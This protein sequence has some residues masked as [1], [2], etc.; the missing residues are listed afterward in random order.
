MVA[1]AAG[2]DAHGDIRRLAIDGVEN[3]AGLVVVAEGGVGIAG[4]LDGFASDVDEVERLIG[5]DLAGD[6]A[7]A[8]G[9]HGFAGDATGGVAGQDGVEDGVGD[10]ITEFVGVSFGDGLRGKKMPIRAC[11]S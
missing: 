6:H 2:V 10:A 5:R 11:Q 9:D 7:E 4:V 3:G 1:R 8:G